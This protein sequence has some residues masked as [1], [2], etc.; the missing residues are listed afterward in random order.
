M[1]EHKASYDPKDWYDLQNRLKINT[2]SGNHAH[3][4]AIVATIAVLITGSVLFYRLQ[5][6]SAQANL[7]SENDRFADTNNQV[8]RLFYP[9]GDS[10]EINIGNDVVLNPEVL[11]NFPLDKTTSNNKVSN[12]T[13]VSTQ[14]SADFSQTVVVDQ[15]V[16]TTK[17]KAPNSVGFTAN[18]KEACE[19]VEV[20][21]GVTNGPKEG[22]YLWNFGDGHFSSD[23]NPKHKFTKAG[24]YDISLSITS[25]YGQINTTVMPDL[26]TIRPTP[27]ANFKWEFVN[28]NPETPQLKIVN[29]SDNASSYQWKF[30]DGTTSKDVSPTIDAAKKGKQLVTLLVVNEYGCKDDAVKTIMVNADFNIGASSGFNP[31]K[32]NFMPAGLKDNKV[33]FE[34]SI[35]TT[36]G[37]KV[38]ETIS[39]TKGW[40]GKLADGSIAGDGSQYTWKVVMTTDN[41][42]EEKYFN[43]IVTIIP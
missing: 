38:Y 4:V 9:H 3:A 11:T 25:D 20:E 39:K 43:G 30:A 16:S 32:D 6:A 23:I 7:A 21:F 28:E 8:L 1:S 24:T 33:K 14:F 26:I 12:S 37:V 15:P 2:K 17:E 36:F 42:K 35:Y 27:I 22:S 13:E 41:S 34:M 31:S 40:D 5:F 29:N 19:G 18:T 10:A